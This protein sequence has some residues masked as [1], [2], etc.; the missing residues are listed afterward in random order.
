MCSGRNGWHPVMCPVGDR[1]NKDCCMGYSGV[2]EKFGKLDAVCICRPPA[3]DKMLYP[4]YI[5]NSCG[6]NIKINYETKSFEENGNKGIN[7][8]PYREL[9]RGIPILNC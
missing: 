2:C 9:P 1:C 8:H 3:Y 5:A 4:I 6:H 7:P